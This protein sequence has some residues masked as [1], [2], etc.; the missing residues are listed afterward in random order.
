MQIAIHYD[1]DCPFC[2]RYVRW[3]RLRETVG[4]VRLVDLRV[5]HAARERLRAQGHDLD[6][7][8]VVEI[9]GQAHAGAEAVHRL[10]LLSTPSDRFNRLNRWVLGHHGASAWVYPWLR[11]GRN[12]T[13]FLLGREALAMREAGAAA[14]FTVF[15]WCW[16]AYALLHVMVY[17]YHYGVPMFAT[18]WAVVVAG[19]ALL[20]VPASRRLFVLLAIALAL[21]AWQHMP[22]Y[23]NHTMLQNVVLAAMGAAGLWQWWCGGRWETFFADV[24]VVGRCA[25][26]TMYFFGVFHKVNTDFLNPQVSCALVLWREM[27]AW[28]AW[29][30]FPGLGPLLAWGTLAVETAIAC[31]L[32]RAR[33]RHAGIVLGMG[34]HKIGRAHV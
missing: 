16:A 21:D 6:Q 3:L 9:D 22:I 26:L 12:A 30:D 20:V 17:R 10:A 28:L 1:G 18:G 32:L 15:A 34:F 11:A 27:P 33:W 5:D 25:L 8:M 23:S 14:L 24:A 2:A 31:M 29:L 4:D 13:L 7:G 19:L